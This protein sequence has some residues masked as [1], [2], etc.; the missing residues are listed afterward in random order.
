M[1]EETAKEMKGHIEKEMLGQR[2]KEIE[3][4]KNIVDT[5]VAN[6]KF[7][8]M[9]LDIMDINNDGFIYKEEFV[10]KF[11]VAIEKVMLMASAS[12]TMDL[13][14]LSEMESFFAIGAQIEKSLRAKAK[15]T[16]TSNVK[17]G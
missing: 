11:P 13:S 15:V 4:A 10:S 17:G 9:L 1:G 6:E 7:V 16:T 12:N 5:Y 8:L 3:I 2:E 14:D